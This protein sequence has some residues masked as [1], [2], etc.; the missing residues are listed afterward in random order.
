[1]ALPGAAAAAG[2]GSRLRLTRKKPPAPPSSS[3]SGLGGGGQKG[4][5]SNSCSWLDQEGLNESDELWRLL[6]WRSVSSSLNRASQEMPD[7]PAFF[8]KSTRNDENSQQPVVF[9]VG[10]EEFRW[11]PFPPA[12]P[13]VGGQFK[14]LDS[15]P[16]TEETPPPR[17]PQEQEQGVGPQSSGPS[18]WAAG[19]CES[20]DPRPGSGAGVKRPSERRDGS[21]KAVKSQLPQPAQLSQLRKKQRLREEGGA[22][23]PAAPQTLAPTGVT[24]AGRSSLRAPDHNLGPGAREEK[25]TASAT[26]GQGMV[27]LDGC[28]MCQVPF[29]GTLSQLDIDS[30][31]AKC[32]SES[33]EDVL[34]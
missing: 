14:D 22:S 18:S 23:S 26:A 5:A 8:D 2:R 21:T 10:T 27:A 9:K 32:L 6:V 29:T 17:A 25:D 30:H 15:S 4:R 20:Q 3:S 34:W 12:F 28:P 7:L 19:S 1:M 16:I 33:I 24:P 11:I 31:L 13:F